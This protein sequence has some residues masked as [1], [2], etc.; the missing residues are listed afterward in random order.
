MDT[1]A[2]RPQWE[3]RSDADIIF[4]PGPRIAPDDAL[5]RKGYEA[6]I[7]WMLEPTKLTVAELKKHPGGCAVK[8]SPCLPTESTKSRVLQRLPRRWSSPLPFLRKGEMTPADPGTKAQSSIGP[9]VAKDFPLI[10]TT[11]ARL[12]M[13]IHSRTFRL[14]WMRSLRRAPWWI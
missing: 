10:L 2:I 5:M 9:D 13:F 8:T 12:P 7:D 3:S 11:G 6:C 1:P 14:G 4:R